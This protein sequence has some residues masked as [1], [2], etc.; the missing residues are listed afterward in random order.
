MKNI[1]NE[2]CEKKEALEKLID[3]VKGLTN[4]NVLEMY[5]HDYLTEHHSNGKSYLWYLDELE[6]V[7]VCIETLEVL[8]DFE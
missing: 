7:A 3:E 5:E 4:E 6:N 8:I 2:T 1:I